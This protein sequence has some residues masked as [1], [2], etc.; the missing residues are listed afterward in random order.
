MNI[1]GFASSTMSMRPALLAGALAA[2]APAVAQAPVDPLVEAAFEAKRAH[3]A[4]YADHAVSTAF[5]QFD[6]APTAA[7]ANPVRTTAP[8]WQATDPASVY[9]LQTARTLPPIDLDL[10]T[11]RLEGGDDGGDCFFAPWLTAGFVVSARAKAVLERFDLGPSR[12]VPVQV[13]RGDKTATHYA[14]FSYATAAGDIDLAKS[15]FYFGDPR[16]PAGWGVVTLQHPAASVNN[17][18]PKQVVLKTV[19]APALFGLGEMSRAWFAR[20][21]VAEALRKAGVRGF[22]FGPNRQVY[23]PGEPLGG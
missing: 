11:F 2:A 15:S 14:L 18:A 9:S 10:G 4:R 8:V 20:R 22:G 7:Y 17:L 3:E 23:A 1:P 16:D 19:P 21:E 6:C 12:F 13:A 5:V